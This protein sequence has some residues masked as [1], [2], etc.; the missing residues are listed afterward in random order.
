MLKGMVHIYTGDG[1]GKTTCSLGLALRASGW[2]KKICII[3]FFKKGSYGE[4]KA[5]K[6][7]KNILVRQFGRKGFATDSGCEKLK[8]YSKEALE[9]S[10]QTV[11]GGKFN[12]IILDE[13]I[14]A[15]KLYYIN[16]RDILELIEKKYISTE[17]VLT[18]RGAP[19]QLINKADLVTEMK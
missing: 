10:R 5:L 12:I 11:S 8:K 15:Y 2:R 13:I 4:I 6:K 17:L 7:F 3:Q 9:F 14:T 16:L 19:K 18:G 1:K